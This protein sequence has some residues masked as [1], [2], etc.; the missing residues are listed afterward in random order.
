MVLQ[1]LQRN[2]EQ[3]DQH[4]G[5]TPFYQPGDR[6]WLSTR[7]FRFGEGS[8]KLQPKY[9]GPFKIIQGV[10]DVTYKLELPPWFR[11]SNSFH[12]SLLKPVV[13]S[14][15]NEA[16]PDGVPPAPLEAEG[17]PVYT[18]HEVLDLRRRGGV[19]QY[20]IDLNF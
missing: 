10:S 9:I 8:R 7:D 1:A 6:V 18:V 5:E 20:L 14:P 19:L 3:A 4:R 2:K 12:V 13:L 15:L 17:G 11:V 16:S